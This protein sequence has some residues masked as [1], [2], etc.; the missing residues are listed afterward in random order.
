MKSFSANPIRAVLFDLDGLLID[1]E[2]L[3]FVC[4]R[5]ALSA[6]GVHLEEQQYLD[7][8]TRDGLGIRDFCER[9]NLSINP[10]SLREHKAQLYERR[11]LTDLNLMPGARE[12]LEMLHG[13]KL[14]AL[15]TAGYPQAVNPALA[16]LDL[17]KYFRAIVTR[18]D[19]K[20]FKPAPDVFLRAAELL[21]VP[22]SQCVVLEDAEKGIRAAHAAKMA[23]I[24]IPTRH[25]QDNDFSLAD[26]IL[27]SLENLTMVVLESVNQ[28]A[29]L[30]NA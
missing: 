20:N 10:D 6:I 15:A 2:T 29:P 22:P 8:W 26:L 1:S 4:W 21:E 28:N 18:S 16:K 11:V 13:Q 9:R 5:E 24:A 7:H 25:T 17:G 3:H 12:C 30:R 14:L 19:V 27:P 23:C